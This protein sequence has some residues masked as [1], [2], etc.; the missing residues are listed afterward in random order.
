M[1]IRRPEEDGRGWTLHMQ[2]EL[3]GRVTR[4]WFILH[5]ARVLLALN[6]KY[7]SIQTHRTHRTKMPRPNAP[8]ARTFLL[9]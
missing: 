7:S 3:K 6:N 4:D 1:E 8:D 5:Y 2:V 9:M